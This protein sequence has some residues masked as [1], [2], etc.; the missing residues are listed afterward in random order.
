MIFWRENI[1]RRKGD[2]FFRLLYDAALYGKPCA[3]KS[4]SGGRIFEPKE[5]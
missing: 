1:C 4:A 5:T 2:I 3:G